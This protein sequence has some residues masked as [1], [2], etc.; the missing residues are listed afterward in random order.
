MTKLRK[1][2]IHMH[3]QYYNTY[4]VSILTLLHHPLPCPERDVK[5]SQQK[6]RQMSTHSQGIPDGFPLVLHNTV[7]SGRATTPTPINMSIIVY[8]HSVGHSTRANNFR[9]LYAMDTIQMPLNSLRCSA[10]AYIQL[11]IPACSEN[12]KPVYSIRLYGIP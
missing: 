9:I 12:L 10:S 6:I 4:T 3:V 7:L 1:S 2:I 5:G 8:L 11:H